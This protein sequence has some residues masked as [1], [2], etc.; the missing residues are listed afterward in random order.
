MNKTKLFFFLGLIIVFAA[1]NGGTTDENNEETNEENNKAETIEISPDELSIE[2][3]DVKNTE[4][5]DAAAKIE[6]LATGIGW[7]EGPVWVDELEALLFSDVAENKIYKWS[8]KDSLSVYLDKAGFA[9]DE[10][11]GY[12]VGPNGLL[13]DPEG[14]LLV[15]QQGNRQIGL[16]SSGLA[17]PQN[18]FLSIA[19]QYDGEKYNSPNDLALDSEGNLYFSDPPYGQ[20]DTKTTE[21]GVNGVYRVDTNGDVY[22]LV[23]SLKL[24]NGI[25]FSE[26]EKTIYI[27]NSDPNFPVIYSYELNEEKLFT[28]GKIFFDFTEIIKTKP[29]KPDGIKRHKSGN[30]FTAGP[31][32]VSVISP[33]GKLLASFNTGRPTANCAFD[34][35]QNYLYM[36]ARE[37]LM[38][39]KLK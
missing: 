26:D 32:G 20:P 7:G 28:N 9:G 4:F 14:D 11:K 13:L 37:A 3:I 29:G 6:V 22:L 35:E 2:I 12:D 36:T 10:P 34:A 39:V 23:D 19:A 24:P 33:K 15:C 38:R 27:T 21:I 1:C 30:L 17:N 5:I 18:N 8:E 25:A 31:G 16:M